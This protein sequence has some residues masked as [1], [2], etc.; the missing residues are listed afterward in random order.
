MLRQVVSE[1]L[2]LPPV[3]MAISLPRASGTQVVPLHIKSL[4]FPDSQ[5]LRPRAPEDQSE[6]RE[7]KQKLRT[8]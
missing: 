2:S 5:H 4:L 8:L 1:N 7:G 3:P 6:T